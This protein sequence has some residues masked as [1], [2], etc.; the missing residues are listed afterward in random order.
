M[1]HMFQI[2][3]LIQDAWHPGQR[4]SLICIVLLPF[5][6]LI[7]SLFPVWTKTQDGRPRNP[8][9]HPFKMVGIPWLERG[10]TPRRH[11]NIPDDGIPSNCMPELPISHINTLIASIRHSNCK[12]A[13][14][15]PHKLWNGNW[16]IFFAF[17]ATVVLTHTRVLCLQ[18]M[19]W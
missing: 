19:R 7:S 9:S 8:H 5:F 6:F 15:A 12:Y 3:F 1:K 14:I 17:P 13:G 11:G 18:N 16:D 4:K 10:I 2:T